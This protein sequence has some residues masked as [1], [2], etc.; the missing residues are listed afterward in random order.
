M[1]L[2]VRKAAE[3]WKMSAGF[4][5]FKL[6]EVVIKDQI[7]YFIL[8]VQT[9]LHTPPT[10]PKISLPSVV[11]CCIVDILQFKIQAASIF[12]TG[13]LGSI[14]NPSFLCILGTRMLFNLKEAGELGV[15]K[16]TSYR[17]TS[18]TISTMNFT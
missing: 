3:Y 5:G 7:I 15:N 17:M 8:Y 11:A 6:V 4:K 10:R 12:W 13:V 2:A 9:V 1:I 18:S 16:G 14:G